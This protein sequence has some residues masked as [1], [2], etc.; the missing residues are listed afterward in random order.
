MESESSEFNKSIAVIRKKVEKMDQNRDQ[1]A[2]YHHQCIDE[3]TSHLR[4]L[5]C[6]KVLNAEESKIVSPTRSE[7]P[8][9]FV[10]VIEVKDPTSIQ[11]SMGS[12]ITSASV[13][14]ATETPENSKKESLSSSP[15]LQHR[16]SY[17][18]RSSMDNIFEDNC[19]PPV[20]SVEK[21]RK[22]PPRYALPIIFIIIFRTIR[23]RVQ[24][25]WKLTCTSPKATRTHR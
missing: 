3:L 4:N 2:Q 20:Q 21:K 13:A 9:S 5:S 24:N 16:E 22:I 10:T 14:I 8:T 7:T 1:G 6:D 18:S 19:M 23:I 12:S 17:G 11:M 15:D 25:I